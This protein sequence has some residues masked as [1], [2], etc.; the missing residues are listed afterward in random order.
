MK[1]PEDIYAELHAK[2]AP[3]ENAACSEH[4]D[5]S[6]IYF[7]AQCR[8]TTRLS[9][10]EELTEYLRG[11]PEATMHDMAAA[12]GC[13]RTTTSNYLGAL[14]AQGRITRRKVYGFWRYSLV[15]E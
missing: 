10:V 3:V 7:T 2:V 4:W 14:R 12:L 6:R 13:S 11:H 1:H 8:H 15:S 9:R 5:H